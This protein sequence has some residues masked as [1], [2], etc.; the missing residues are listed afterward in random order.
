[1][2]DVLRQSSVGDPDDD[3]VLRGDV[4][5]KARQQ[6]MNAG[7][8]EVLLSVK[9]LYGEGGGG[10]GGGG[11][12]SDSGS[13]KA[14]RKQGKNTNDEEREQLEKIN[15]GMMADEMLKGLGVRVVKK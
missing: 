12:K 13:D 6:A 4:L 8:V 3:R 7:A 10:G 2:F 15:V 1:M 5:T 14:M 11:G 9:K